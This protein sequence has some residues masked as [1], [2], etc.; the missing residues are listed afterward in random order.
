MIYKIRVPFLK[1]TLNRLFRL[2]IIVNYNINIKVSNYNKMLTK[3]LKDD[4]YKK[5]KWYINQ[6]KWRLVYKLQFILHLIILKYKKINGYLICNFTLSTCNC[7]FLNLMILD[8]K[9]NRTIRYKYDFPLCFRIN[10]ESANIFSKKFYFHRLTGS[11]SM[12]LEV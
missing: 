8:L 2:T 4:V 11:K 5:K 1:I 3:E 7:F 9:K 10:I 6:V 12:S